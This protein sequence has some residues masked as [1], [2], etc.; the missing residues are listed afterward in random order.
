LTMVA[1]SKAGACFE[2]LDAGWKGLRADIEL[3][4]SAEDDSG[5]A[6]WVIEDPLSGR[7]FRVGQVES[8]VVEALRG[9]ATP[10]AA[11][12]RVH[13]LGLP[14]PTP[15]ALR[16]FLTE[17]RCAGL[18]LG[19]DSQ[20]GSA[21]VVQPRFWTRLLH[22]YVYY[23]IPLL[24]P[25]AWL[26][27]LAPGLRPL[28][29]PVVARALRYIGL[30]GVLL[31]LPQAQLYFATVSYLL[32]PTGFVS[33]IA[34][35]V[36]LKLGHELAHAFSAKFKGI[37]V[38]SMGVAF[39]LLW[40]IL[41]TD[42]TDAWREPERRRRALVGSAGIRFELA[43]AGIALLLWS[44]LPDGVLRSLAF[45]LSSASILS[46]LLV[47]LNPFMRFDGYYLLMD[48]WG[49]DNLQPRAF[50]LL[51]HRLR[52]VCLGW[53][54]QAPEAPP[55]A[56]QM[57]AY[58]VATLAYRVFVAIAI[59]TAVFA[60]IGAL[61][62][63]VVA[64]LELYILLLRPLGRE[65]RALFVQRANIGSSRRALAT[66]SLLGASVLALVLP[67]ERDLAVPGLLMHERL[68]YVSTP[69]EGRI[70]ALPPA[71]GT[72]VEEG[73]VLLVLESAEQR[74]ALDRLDIELRHN[75]AQQQAFDTRGSEGGYR[76]WLQEEGRRLIAARAAAE[77]RLAQRVV[78][79]AAAGE[80]VERH[81]DYQVGDSV[82]ADVVLA[83]VRQ[84]ARLR[85]N[86]L[87]GDK[88]GALLDPAGLTRA[89]LRPWDTGLPALDVAVADVQPR[90]AESLTS[91]AL[92]DRFGG[93]IAA[94]QAGGKAHGAGTSSALRAGTALQPRDAYQAF[95]FIVDLPVVADRI[96]DATP[97]WVELQL[98]PVSILGN[99]FTFLVRTVSR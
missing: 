90:A 14:Q 53:R 92:Y 23:R 76:N 54:G 31:A 33:F 79:A 28:A 61:A 7:Y 77:L 43:V 27:R 48:V 6:A 67:M 89:R 99:F 59:A 96:P 68:Q 85:V 73:A 38:R 78:H 52:R 97:V 19:N 75:R 80:L 10:S 30:L 72:T 34:C 36:V 13:G 18:C 74:H 24:R 8:V 47:N 64:A 87:V 84:S 15:A 86:A 42:V 4:A 1:V 51:R 58:A 17:L 93:P 41:Y 66:L 21:G 62:G 94:V 39:I 69:F 9:G 46:T 55:H 56:P 45:Y 20:A 82:A 40:P 57:V 70:V 81:P 3:R 95:S 71:V 32:S 49:I 88:Y 44:I 65:L 5:Q 12:E 83:S 63:V 35:L 11:I 91:V 37:H 60:F 2:A 29:S 50:A 26:T 98:Q 16:A 22:G 25:D